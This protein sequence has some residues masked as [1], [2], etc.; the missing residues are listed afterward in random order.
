MTATVQELMTAAIHEADLCADGWGEFCVEADPRD[1]A[2]LL[3]TPEGA[4]LAE[5]HSDEAKRQRAI[6]VAVERFLD[7]PYGHLFLAH[8]GDLYV[9]EANGSSQSGPTIAAA[10]GDTE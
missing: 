9:C 2:A 3:A 1:A 8:K 10:L 6:G 7:S 5:P 4:A